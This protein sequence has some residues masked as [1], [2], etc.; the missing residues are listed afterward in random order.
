MISVSV[1]IFADVEAE[2]QIMLPEGTSY[3]EL[4]DLLGI[5]PETVVITRDGVPV[6]FN[7]VVIPG[8]IEIIRVVSAG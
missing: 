4:L 1:R 7:D 5:N 3:Y 2:R 8:E 6:P